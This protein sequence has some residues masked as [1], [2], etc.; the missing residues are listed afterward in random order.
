MNDAS[1]KIEGIE[2]QVTAASAKRIE[3][4]VIPTSFWLGGIK[5]DVVYDDTLVKTRQV[6]AEAQY[7]R[8]RIL[9]DPSA[10]PLQTIEQSYLHELVHWIFYIMG[11]D[12]LRNNERIVDLFAH[13]LYQARMTENMESIGKLVNTTNGG[14]IQEAK[15][16]PDTI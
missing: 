14:G 9:L 8:Q 15:T 3:S 2:G 11:E 4:E 13:L 16:T 6:I 10:T 5:I 1:R 12:E 7:G